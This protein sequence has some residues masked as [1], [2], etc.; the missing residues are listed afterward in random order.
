[1]RNFRNAVN[2]AVTIAE[3]EHGVGWHYLCVGP[4]ALCIYWD[5]TT[6]DEP[7]RL[8]YLP[9]VDVRHRSFGIWTTWFSTAVAIIPAEDAREDDGEGDR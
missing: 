1:V 8:R 4:V 2:L 6:T 7:Q 9:R 3:N 5:T